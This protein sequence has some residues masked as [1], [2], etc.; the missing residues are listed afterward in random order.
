MNYLLNMLISFAQTVNY[1][2]EIVRISA[3][4]YQYNFVYFD[5][6]VL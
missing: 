1:I 3:F 6:E 4:L 5:N 2:A